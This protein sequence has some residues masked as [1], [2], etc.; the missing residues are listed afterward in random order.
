M[1]PRVPKVIFETFPKPAS[2]VVTIDSD[3]HIICTARSPDGSRIISGSTYG[4]LKFWDGNTLR[5]VPNSFRGPMAWQLE[6]SEDQIIWDYFTGKL[7]TKIDSDSTAAV[8]FSADGRRVVS[9]HGNSI[10]RIWDAQNGAFIAGI[11]S[12]SDDE[13]VRI[14]DAQSGAAIEEPL[15]GHEKSVRAVA[16]SPD[17]SRI[18]SGSWDATVRIWDAH[19][20]VQIGGPLEGYKNTVVDVGYSQDGSRIISVSEDD[21]IRFWN[22]TNGDPIGVLRRRESHWDAERQHFVSIPSW[23]PA[24][25]WLKSF[26]IQSLVYSSNPLYVPDNGWIRALDRGLPLWVPPQHR[27]CSCHAPRESTITANDRDERLKMSA[28]K[29]VPQGTNWTKMM[30][31][32]LD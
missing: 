31:A 27:R 2:D 7:V 30:N 9:G 16:Y 19:T 12:G 25:S 17:G 3:R 5:I 10:L 23:W 13:S 21:M 1:R 6:D 26:T 24:P 32:E 15:K 20:G 29:D 22:A 28:W 18:V 8:A 4:R 14:W 11:V